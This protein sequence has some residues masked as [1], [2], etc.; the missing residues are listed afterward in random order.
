[1]SE[2]RSVA[3]FDKNMAVVTTITEPDLV[4]LSVRE[5]PFTIYGVTYDEE[6]KTFVR[7]PQSVADSVSGGVSSLNRH[8][9]GG[10]V[11]FVTNSPCIAIHAVMHNQ[12]MMDHFALTGLSGFDLYHKTEEGD[13]YYRTFRPPV[14]MKEGYSSLIPTPAELSV[15][16]IN[17]PLYDTVKELYIGLKKDAVLE[18]APGYTHSKPA[19]FYGSSITQG[20]CAS[21][22]GNAYEAILS[23]RLDL[24]YINLG[25]SGSGK[26][27]PEIREYIAHM[28]MSIFVCDYDHNA[29]A[30]N[31][32]KET[33]MPLLRAV[34]AVQPDLPILVLSAPDSLLKPEWRYRRE[35]IREN[36]EQLQS[37][38]DK[39][40]YF[41]DGITLFEGEGWD[42]CTVDGCHPNDLG[43]LRMANKIEPHIKRLLGI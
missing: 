40:I 43:F 10:R 8:T 36:V 31:Y 24:D 32:L 12:P 7:M 17:F 37:E 34:R 6:Q 19:V 15:Y 42:S 18:A 26:A 38:G 25:F 4:W 22:P 11:R 21:R 30:P 3:D 1:M 9:A 16:T 27:E 14:G 2:R 5:A 13:V 33:H 23:R 29:Y 39:N 41:L 35:I 28:D 20:G